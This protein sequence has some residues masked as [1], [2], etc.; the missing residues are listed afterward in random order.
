MRPHANSGMSVLEFTLVVVIFSVLG[1]IFLNATAGLRVEIERA[2]VRQTLN[3]MRSALA[4][5]F[6]ELRIRG[7]DEAI[8]EWEGGDALSLLQDTKAQDNGVGDMAATVG[9]PGE[10]RYEDGVIIYRPSYPRELAGNPNAVGRW[11]VVV[12]GSR[13][14]PRGLKLRTV[15]PLIGVEA[16][17]Q[18]DNRGYED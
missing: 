14:E 2:A 16:G 3:Q 6:A 7:D 17:T 8:A 5:R 9:G 12:E 18:G 11:E 4:V 10:W 13:D 1:V 15:D